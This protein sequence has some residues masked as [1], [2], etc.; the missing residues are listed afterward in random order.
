MLRL[1]VFDGMDTDDDQVMVTANA[2]PVPVNR[3]PVPSGGPFSLSENSPNGTSVGTVT[4]GDPDA[5]QTHA[6]VITG[7]GNTGGAFAINSGGQITVANSAALDFETRPSFTLTVQVTDNGTPAM[8]GTT[9]VTVNLTDVPEAP[10]LNYTNNVHPIFS[11]TL[12]RLNGLPATTCIACHTGASA[13]GGLNL[14]ASPAIV[15]VNLGSRIDTGTP[16]NSSILRNPSG[17]DGEAHGG[18][19]F[20]SFTSPGR[21]DY[22]TILHW[23]AGTD[24]FNGTAVCPSP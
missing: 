2:A 6:F 21:P 11:A 10:S 23:I 19:K 15:C 18:G 20:D 12:A 4:A 8:S 13:S 9:T 24:G 3:A 22:D 17:D 1:R 7:S 14:N 16:A 5:G